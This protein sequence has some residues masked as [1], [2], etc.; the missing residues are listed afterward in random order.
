MSVASVPNW[1]PFIL[2]PFPQAIMPLFLQRLG[3]APL[4]VLLSLDAAILPFSDVIVILSLIL[5]LEEVVSSLQFLLC[6]PL[7]SSLFPIATLSSL[8]YSLTFVL[9]SLLYA[10]I[11]RL[12]LLLTFISHILIMSVTYSKNTLTFLSVS[13]AI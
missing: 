3:S 4:S 11:S 7:L 2:I 1:S 10:H 9:N 6:S 12:H 5:L 13:W 8:L